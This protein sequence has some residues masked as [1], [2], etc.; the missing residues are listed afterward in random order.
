ME[1]TKNPAASFPADRTRFA[2]GLIASCIGLA[3][4][5][6][7][8]GMQLYKPSDTLEFALLELG[9]L[10]LLVLL[11][12]RGWCTILRF[13]P[14]GIRTKRLLRKAE[15]HSYREYGFVCLMQN[16]PPGAGRPPVHRLFLPSAGGAFGGGRA[17]A[18]GRVF[19]EELSDA[20][21]GA[22]AGHGG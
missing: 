8:L 19:R 5:L 10:A 14:A 21:G 9:L 11:V 17:A 15:E 1:N 20:S 13:T 12:K 16:T 7:A 18:G 22:P 2:A 4:M 6:A 3:L